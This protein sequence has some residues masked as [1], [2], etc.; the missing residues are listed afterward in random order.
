[1]HELFVTY[2]NLKKIST[3]RRHFELVCRDH[4]ANRSS[5]FC[6]AEQLQSSDLHAAEEEDRRSGA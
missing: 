4:F 3:Q 5:V 6:K 1:M 2:L